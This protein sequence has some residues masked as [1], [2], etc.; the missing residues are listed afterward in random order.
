MEAIAIYRAHPRYRLFALICV[1]LVLLFAWQLWHKFEAGSA[2]FF[3]V[4]LGLLAWYGRAAGSRVEVDPTRLTLYT[5]LAAPRSVE[6]RQLAG[7]SEEGRMGQ[8]ILVLYHPL[9]EHGLVELDEIRSLALP[10]MTDQETLLA[11]LARQVP[12]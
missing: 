7:V 2:I 6:F 4:V 12:T 11:A 3:V 10:A 1:G 9:R 8:A 5:P